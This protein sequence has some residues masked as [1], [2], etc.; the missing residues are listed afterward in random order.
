MFLRKG[1]VKICSIFTGEHPCRSVNLIKL[2]SKFIEIT[3]RHGC[4]PVNLLHIF[5]TLFP[6]NTS[7]WLL[8]NIFINNLIFFIKDVE[9][10]K[11][12]DYN[13]IYAARNSKEKF[14]K[15][16]EKE[17]MS[18]I[19]W[20]K[21]NDM[22]VNPEKFQALIMSCDKKRKQVWFEYKQLN[23]FICRLCYTF[24][25]WNRQQIEFWKACFNHLFKKQVGN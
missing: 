3:L 19:D 11:F 5:R 15:V 20:L 17:S 18:A 6:K 16:L 25:Y 23:H 2:Q 13:T 1:V 22:I 24:K 21:M 14:M 12:A 8:L 9:L 10:A 7:G 4:S